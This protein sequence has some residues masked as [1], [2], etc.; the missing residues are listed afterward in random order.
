MSEFEHVFRSI[1]A[2]GMTSARSMSADEETLWLTLIRTLVSSIGASRQFQGRDSDRLRDI[3]MAL[4][5]EAS[6]VF[7][8]ASPQMREAYAEKGYMSEDIGISPEAFEEEKPYK[9]ERH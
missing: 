7:D 3:Y 9:Q 4:M 8:G 1:A 5:V 2:R 6:M